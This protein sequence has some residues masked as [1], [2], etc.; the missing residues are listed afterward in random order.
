LTK[1]QSQEL[2]IKEENNYESELDLNFEEIIEN[3]ISETPVNY[4][5]AEDVLPF[6]ISLAST[7]KVLDLFNPEAVERKKC[8]YPY[9][10]IFYEDGSIDAI[11]ALTGEKDKNL[12]VED[13]LEEIPK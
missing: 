6:K 13:V 7:D 2:I 12:P 8:Y 11:D 4:K 9:W 10:L 1:L 5:Y 3:Q